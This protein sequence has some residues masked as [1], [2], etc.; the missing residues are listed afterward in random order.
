MITI[1][2]SEERGSANLGW[3]ASRHSFSFGDYFDA[4]HMG[5]GPLRVI[6]EDWVR[7]GAGFATH[8]HRDMEIVTFVIEGA[9]A[10]KDSTGGGSTIHPGNVQRMTAGTGVRHS[11]YNA[12]DTEP[13]HLLQ[14]W[15]L[16]DEAGL[17]PGYEEKLFDLDGDG[18]A[19]TLIAAPGGREGSLTIHQDAAVFHGRLADGG[20]V[21]HAPEPGRK[22]WI[23]VIS[24]ALAVNGTQASAGD[25]LAVSDEA[26]LEIAGARDAEFLLFDMAG[27]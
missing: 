27:D 22:L 5:F 11:E 4:D 3:L 6:N 15:I 21:T 7:P 9:L 10:H 19:L 2:P 24:G 17:A 12:S 20:S 8:G 25:G 16:P 18:G 1:R 13:V 14:I 26:R 23:Q